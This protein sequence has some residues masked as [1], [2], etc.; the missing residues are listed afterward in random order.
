MAMTRMHALTQTNAQSD[1]WADHIIAL[2]PWEAEEEGHSIL[3]QPLME[4]VNEMNLV[5]E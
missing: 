3:V 4:Q 2:L 5:T 1:R